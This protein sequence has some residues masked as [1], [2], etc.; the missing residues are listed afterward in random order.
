M[1]KKQDN[2]LLVVSGPSGSG[3]NT[4]IDFILECRG[5][6]SHSVSATTRAPRGSE[7][8]GVDYYFVSFEEFEKIALEGGFYEF[9]EYRNNRYGTLKSDVKKRCEKGN[10]ILDLTVPGA[11]NLKNE[12]GDRAKSVFIFPPSVKVLRDRLVNRASDSEETIE[13]RIRFA[14]NSEI[15]KYRHFDF[16]IFNDKLE[17][18]K[19]AILDI[20]DSL[21]SGEKDACKKADCY[22]TSNVSERA[23]ETIESFRNEAKDF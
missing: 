16:I 17:D 1:E 11:L 23:E 21:T 10:V 15:D 7:K 8:D 2:L 3:K 19:R 9:D 14:L 6:L 4:L 13:K 5:N 18:S 20:Y 12:F 22:R